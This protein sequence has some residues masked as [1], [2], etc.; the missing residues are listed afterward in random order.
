MTDISLFKKAISQVLEKLRAAINQQQASKSHQFL[1]RPQRS[2]KV[3]A[4]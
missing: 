3:A 4:F 2:L 1:S